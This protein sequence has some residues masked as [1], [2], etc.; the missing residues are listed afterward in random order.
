MP[1]LPEGAFSLGLYAPSDTP[2]CKAVINKKN[3]CKVPNTR[4]VQ[5]KLTVSV[6]MLSKC[7]RRLMGC[8]R[9]VLFIYLGSLTLEHF[10]TSS[11][12]DTLYGCPTLICFADLREQS[13]SYG[14][15]PYHRTLQQLVVSELLDPLIISRTFSSSNSGLYVRTKHHLF[16]SK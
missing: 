5:C 16:A 15:L 2:R 10:E 13:A 6:V 8:S 1:Q 11:G 14:S 12:K 4:Y 9:A 3:I 7:F